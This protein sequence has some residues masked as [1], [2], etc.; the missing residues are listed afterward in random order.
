M[1]TFA[2]PS[3]TDTYEL[4]NEAGL[5]S[6]LLEDY[7]LEEVIFQTPVENLYVRPAG[8]VPFDPLGRLE[9][10]QVQRLLQEVKQR[11]DIVL[12]TPAPSSASVTRP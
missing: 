2:A 8:P 10:T 11:F 5:T 12:V 4:D 3:C 6:Y 1:R 7:P 9:L